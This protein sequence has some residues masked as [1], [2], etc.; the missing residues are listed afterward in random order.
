M[1]KQ[2]EKN[3]W[4]KRNGAYSFSIRVQSTINHIYLFFVYH[5]NVKENG[6][7][8][9]SERELKKALRDT[10]TTSKQEENCVAQ[11]LFDKES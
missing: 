7:F 4:E 5:I 10:H 6:F 8:C 3:V 9:F 1:Q 11:S 2:Y